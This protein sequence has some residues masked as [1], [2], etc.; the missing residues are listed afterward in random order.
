MC[1]GQ[2]NQLFDCVSLRL[3]I[4]LINSNAIME[5]MI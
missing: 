5:E 4:Y 1:M 3:T 2:A